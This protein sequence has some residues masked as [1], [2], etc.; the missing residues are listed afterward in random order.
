[1]YQNSILTKANKVYYLN[2]VQDCGE[3]CGESDRKCSFTYCSDMRCLIH[4]S[5]EQ[6]TINPTLEDCHTYAFDP[7]NQIAS[8][9]HRMSAKKLVKHI[10][11]HVRKL[12]VEVGKNRIF[13]DD[14]YLISGPDD[15]GRSDDFDNQDVAGDLENE[16]KLAQSNRKIFNIDARRPVGLSYIQC[17]QECED[18]ADC[19]S[20]SYCSG[21][22]DHDNECLI[23]ELFGSQ[24]DDRE[25]RV[26][27]K[28]NIYTSEL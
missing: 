5:D 21:D 16:Y 20:L 25:T 15:I 17:L 11:E 22:K 10:N 1:V 19:H 14:V 7:E 13:A 3:I 28:C 12:F 6:Y 9:F 8:K 18:N 27:E 4:D 23:S 2:S 24:L 26:N